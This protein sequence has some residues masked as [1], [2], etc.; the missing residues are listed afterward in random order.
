SAGFPRRSSGRPDR[1]RI[2]GPGGPHSA[3][4]VDAGRAERGARLGARGAARE[5]AV[6]LG[7][8]WSPTPYAHDVLILPPGHAQA[9]RLRRRLTTRERRLIAGMLAALAAL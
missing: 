8:P 6:V 7:H 2:A 4:G 5:A 3:H 1:G 9:V